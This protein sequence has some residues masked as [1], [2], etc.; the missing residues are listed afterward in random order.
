MGFYGVGI[1]N[2]TN[3]EYTL[4]DYILETYDSCKSYSISV[5]TRSVGLG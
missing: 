1:T 4:K 3:M 2:I 5:G